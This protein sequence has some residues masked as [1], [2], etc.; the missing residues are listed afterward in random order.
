MALLSFGEQKLLNFLYI[1]NFESSCYF[2]A[3]RSRQNKKIYISKHCTWLFHGIVE[4][5]F[6]IYIHLISCFNIQLARLDLKCFLW[7]LP[8][9][10]K[11]QAVE[12]S[13]YT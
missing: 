6:F 10:L 9:V 5:E 13:I 4:R 3:T 1:N 7:H 12:T 11:K 2:C 8:Y